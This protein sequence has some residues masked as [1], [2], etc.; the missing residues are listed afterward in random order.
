M[1]HWSASRSGEYCFGGRTA[2]QL[3]CDGA[4]SCRGSDG[5]ADGG[6]TFASDASTLP[7]I[8]DAFCEA[9]H[10]PRVS[11]DAHRRKPASVGRRVA[12]YTWPAAF[13][14][15]RYDTM[16]DPA[17]GGFPTDRIRRRT[18]LARCMR[19]GSCS[20][21]SV[22][23]R[24]ELRVVALL[25]R[26]G[27]PELNLSLVQNGPKRLKADRRNDLLLDDIFPQFLKRPAF[28]RAAEKVGWALGGF[29]NKG[30]VVFGKLQR[31][32]RAGFRLESLKAALVKFLDDGSHM[33]LGVVDEFGNRG[34]FEALVGCKH[35]L[36]TSDLDATC[37]A[38]KDA[39][40]LLPF[41]DAEVS[42]VQT[43]KNS[44]SLQNSMESVPC[45][46]LYN[47]RLCMAQVAKS[48][49][50]KIFF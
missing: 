35:H 8:P 10:S 44:L 28:E 9:E 13:S 14:G 19:A 29:R 39:L 43:H 11:F 45:V 17:E 7:E 4:R 38:A 18:P 49:I 22:F 3:V 21:E 50:L 36:C 34:H 42:G 33:M 31:S 27:P 46:C 20:G 37:T 15:D 40:N 5:Y 25:P 24:L 47:N 32:A 48:Q 23:F 26:L 30:S 2:A 16:P 12:A 6:G 1:R 41:A